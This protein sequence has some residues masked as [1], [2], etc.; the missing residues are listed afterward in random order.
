[1][2]AKFRWF[3]R[4]FI[5]E[6]ILYMHSRFAL[7]HLGFTVYWLSGAIWNTTQFTFRKVKNSA[8]SYRES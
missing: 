8:K 5:T 7:N 2:L 6:G 3:Y 1:M 4:N